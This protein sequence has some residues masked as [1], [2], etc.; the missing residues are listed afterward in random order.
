MPDTLDLALGGP[1]CYQKY[2]IYKSSFIEQNGS[3]HVFGK[4]VEW[5]QDKGMKHSRG[6]LYHLQIQGMIKRWY[7]GLKNRIL[8]EYYFFLS[9]LKV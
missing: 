1:G 5:V 4:L 7:Q 6:A 3:S 8:L 9:D 2:N